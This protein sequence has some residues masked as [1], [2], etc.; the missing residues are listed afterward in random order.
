MLA[1]YLNNLKTQI[2]LK[3]CISYHHICTKHIRTYFKKKHKKS[4]AQ[5]LI[6]THTHIFELL[7]ILI[8]QGAVME[9]LKIIFTNN[10]CCPQSEAQIRF[11][12]YFF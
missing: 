4:H 9:K 10:K 3:N 12:A 11:E 8:W 6:K 1:K 2:K 5:S 7:L